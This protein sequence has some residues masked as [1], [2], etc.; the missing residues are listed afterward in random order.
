MPY[1][2]Q[3][4][5]TSEEFEKMYFALLRQKTAA[6]RFQMTS[7]LTESAFRLWC[8]GVKKRNPQWSD[9]EIAI[10][11]VEVHYGKEWAEKVRK[12]LN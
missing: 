9:Q 3:S 11:W 1:K 6:E 7:D 10:H 12:E 2:T 8:G 5:D 4:P